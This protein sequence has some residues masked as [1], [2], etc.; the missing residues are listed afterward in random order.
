LGT[1][2]IL[3][4]AEG[5][6]NAHIVGNRE[7][8]I[9]VAALNRKGRLLGVRDQVLGEEK[10]KYE[11]EKSRRLHGP[12]GRGELKSAKET[13]KATLEKTEIHMAEKSPRGGRNTKG[14]RTRGRGSSPQIKDPS[15]T[16]NGTWMGGGYAVS[17]DSQDLNS[18]VINE[19]DP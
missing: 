17:Q 4:E 5:R 9:L 2:E 6:G 10:V 11:V 14:R 19:G 16:R 8:A 7:F 15:K 3:Q 18:L 1:K 13:V 12:G